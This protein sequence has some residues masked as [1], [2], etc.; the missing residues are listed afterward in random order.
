MFLKLIR[1][2]FQIGTLRSTVEEVTEFW[3]HNL[4]SRGVLKY[5]EN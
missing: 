1:F 3:L 5:T 2:L 4:T